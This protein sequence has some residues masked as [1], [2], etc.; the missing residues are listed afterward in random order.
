MQWYHLPQTCFYWPCPHNDLRKQKSVQITMQKLNTANALP[1]QLLTRITDLGAIHIQGEETSKYLQGQVTIDMNQLSGE[2][3]V[4]GCHCDFKGK[5]WSTFY[6]A[7]TPDAVTLICNDEAKESSLAELKKYGVFSKVEINDVSDEMEIFA[8]YGDYIEG[9]ISSVFG[10]LPEHHLAVV[11]NPNG[12]V[13]TLDDTRRRYLMVLSKA[14]AQALVEDYSER[15]DDPTAWELLDIQA[16]IAQVQGATSNEYVPQ[17]MNLQA[18]G[19]I[20]FDKGC[21]MGQEVVARTKFLGKNKRAAFILK[22]EQTANLAPG[23]TLEMQV[24]ENWRRGGTVL[25]AAN[26][27]EESWILAVLPNDTEVGSLLRSKDDPQ[28]HYDVLPLPYSIEQ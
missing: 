13:I 17:M 6:A 21:Y 23:D 16:G 19:A 1:A 5:T 8:G 3:G 4:M 25:R 14:T 15:L 11:Q 12:F 22:S 26:L 28:L 7:G 9:Y 18:L 10:T 24:G 27:P 20:S 2:Q